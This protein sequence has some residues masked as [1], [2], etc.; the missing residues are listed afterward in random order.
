M[1]STYPMV[2]YGSSGSAVKELQEALNRHGYGLA[3][4]GIFGEKTK[5]A[6]RSYQ[7]KNG[8]KLDGIA[9]DETWGSLMNVTSMEEMAPPAPS[10][11]PN[12]SAAL[13]KLE[14][15]FTPSADTAAALEY[16]K[17]LDAL[18]PAEYESAFDE[19]LAALYEQMNTREAFSYDP[20]ADA[21]FQSYLK[22]YTRD[23]KSVV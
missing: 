19:Q 5:A 21:A 9:G 10:V 3:V 7:K 20:A 4:D 22:R 11:S 13:E 23:R 8:L 1:A 14:Q 17:S 18:V 12:T 6:V 2:A 16:A 15:G